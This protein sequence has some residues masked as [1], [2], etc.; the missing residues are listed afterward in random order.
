MS[1]T[2]FAPLEHRCNEHISADVEGG[3]GR[4]RMAEELGP[5]FT[6]MRAYGGQEFGIRIFS[7]SLRTAD[8]GVNLAQCFQG[9]NLRVFVE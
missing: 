4:E 9:Y 2:A 5:F 7:S 1:R 3:C 8:T 6:W